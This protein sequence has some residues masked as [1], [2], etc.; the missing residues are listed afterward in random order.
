MTMT[1]V[2]LCC[3]GLLF[4]GM[5]LYALGFAPFLFSALPMA[6]ARTVLR[7]AFPH[8]YLF[9]MGTSAIAAILLWQRD[10]VSALALASIAVS[11]MPTRQV[12][13]PAINAA[14]DTGATGRFKLLHA[15]SVLVTLVHIALAGW[16]MTRFA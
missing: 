7:M 16:V 14:T 12:L 8:F 15:L 4:G 5:V 10:G 3:V 13:M 1:M 2:S 11:T 9:L 6:Q